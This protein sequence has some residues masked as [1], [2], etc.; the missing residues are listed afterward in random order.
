MRHLLESSFD[1]LLLLGFSGSYDV[2]QGRFQFGVDDLI[3]S[4]HIDC[5]K[6]EQLLSIEGGF[7]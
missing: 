4:H 3:F 5:F 1:T 2:V 7:D 6:M